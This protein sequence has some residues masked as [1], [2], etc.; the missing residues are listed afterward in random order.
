MVVMTV[1][2][3][4]GEHWPSLGGLVCDWIEDNLVFG[5]G[6]LRGEPAILDDE[7]R[8]LIWR[9]YEIYPQGHAQ[10]GRRRF[11]RVALV[12]PK[13]TAKTELCAW[14]AAAEL[15]PDAPVR[16]V[17]WDEEGD[18]IGGP[19]NDP[20]IP[21]VA[22][23]EEQSDELAYGALKAI[24]EESPIA[25][26]FDIGLERIMRRDGDG[27]VV[28]LASSPNSNDGARTTFQAFDE[29][30]WHTLPRLL[31]SHQT[32]LANIPKRRQSDA[33]SLEI[34]TA[35]EPGVGS[36]AEKTYE[37]ARAVADGRASDSRLFF[38]YRYASDDHDLSTDEGA[39]AAVMEASGPTSVWR[40]I[41][42]IVEL[43]RD[44]TTDR[45]YWERVWLNRL[46]M[47]S[48]QAFDVGLW[49]ELQRDDHPVEDGDLVTLGFD[50]AIFRDSTALVATHVETGYQ[51]MLGAWECP[52]GQ[53]NWEVPT[54]EVDEAIAAAFQRYNVWRLY[55][56]PPYWQA[57]IAKWHGQFGDDRVVEW[58]TNR[59]K[60]MSYSLE[61]F[62]TAIRARDISHNGD[63]T[64]TR[65]IGNSHRHDLPQRDDEGKPMWLIRKERSDSPAK[66]DAAMAAVL[67]WQARA[68]AIKLGAN[69][70]QAQPVPNLW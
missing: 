14:I 34:T 6:D 52:Y 66:I 16:C 19:V 35:H 5:P 28:S 54:D 57:W 1:P 25:G 49:R 56:D 68:D 42:S 29:T 70:Q 9:A 58:W 21:L 26:D 47:S 18:P 55:A 50:G 64:L 38:F 32:M 53:D 7:K 61:A 67:S 12:L 39:R 24:L 41:D 8:G 45:S 2:A 10:A 23:T 44:P 43:W 4:E 20:Y 36:V 60:A 51:W 27:K 31:Q 40:D 17:G 63:E 65:H 11:K 46:V 13:G 15:H 30:H 3:V 62:D 22:Y 37:Y 33:W 59:R 48:R 69:L